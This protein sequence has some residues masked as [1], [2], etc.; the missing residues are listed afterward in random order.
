MILPSAFLT[1]LLGSGRGAGPRATVPSKW[2]LLPW[3]GQLIVPSFTSLTL[4]PVWVQMLEN[5]RKSFG[6]GW[7]TTT[8]SPAKIL[9]PLTG[10]SDAAPNTVPAES[11]LAPLPG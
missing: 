6:A 5:R 4:Q 7:V 10:I 2:Y 1:G 9:P 3:H 11:A 8:S